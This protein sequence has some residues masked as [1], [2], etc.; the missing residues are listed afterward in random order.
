[1]AL[2]PEQMAHAERSAASI[3]AM[4]AAAEAEGCDGLGDFQG[5]FG[6]TLGAIC[7]YREASLATERETRPDTKQALRAA[8][9]QTA[10]LIVVYAQGIAAGAGE[11]ISG[12]PSPAG[13]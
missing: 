13:G 9:T 11:G 10:A 6:R 2:T 5:P 8:A 3:S 1:M 7:T 4:L 12:W